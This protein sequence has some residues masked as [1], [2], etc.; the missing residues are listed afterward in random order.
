MSEGPDN[1]MVNEAWPTVGEF[2]DFDVDA[3]STTTLYEKI[4]DMDPADPTAPD[5]TIILRVELPPDDLRHLIPVSLVQDV[6]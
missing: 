6:D 2:R 5:V 1:R 4:S 3:E